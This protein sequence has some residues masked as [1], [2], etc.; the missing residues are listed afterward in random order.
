MRPYPGRDLDTE[1]C[2]SNYRLSR[3]RRCVENAFGIM[4]ARFRILRKP[5][6]A[7]LTTSQNIVKASVCLHNY[8]RSKE[9][10]MPAKERRY[11]PPGFADTD[12]GSGSILT[13]RWRDENIHNLS[14]VSRSA[15]NM[16]SKNAAA[17]RISYTSYFTREG[18]VPW[19]DA[20]VS[21]K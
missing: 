3:A 7:G 2:V 15:S 20:I 11:C 9:E 17:V 6:I 1:K 19:Q 16:Y 10:Q 5:I 8:L 21:R 4:A 13:G 14:K 18:A 12:D